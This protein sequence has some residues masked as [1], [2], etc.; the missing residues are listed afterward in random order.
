MCCASSP[1][2]G[3]TGIV[4]FH[5]F[6]EGAVWDRDFRNRPGLRSFFFVSFCLAE[7]SPDGRQASGTLPTL[8]HSLARGL[9]ATTTRSLHRELRVSATASVGCLFRFVLPGIY[10]FCIIFFNFH[11]GVC[12]NIAGPQ[13]CSPAGLQCFFCY[14]SG[15]FMEALARPRSIDT[16][17]RRS[18]DVHHTYG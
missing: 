18:Y 9:C 8:L 14:S 17:C 3:Y 15:Y 1:T 5:S 11:F 12:I 6:T 16:P 2:T 7:R 4:F 10:V 13:A